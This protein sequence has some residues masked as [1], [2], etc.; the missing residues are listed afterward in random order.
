MSMSVNEATLV[1]R[2][3]ILSKFRN[4]A[5]DLRLKAD[6]N[7]GTDAELAFEASASSVERVCDE[8]QR[9]HVLSTT[10]KNGL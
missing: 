5:S 10:K 7:I 1:E 9:Q 2:T 4:L 3:H 8:I 6:Q